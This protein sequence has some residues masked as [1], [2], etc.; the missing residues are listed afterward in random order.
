VR[1]DTACMGLAIATEIEGFPPSDT[2]TASASVNA[3]SASTAARISALT[4]TAGSGTPFSA[5]AAGTAPQNPYVDVLFSSTQSGRLLVGGNVNSSSSKGQDVLAGQLYR[6]RVWLGTSASPTD[7][8]SF[9]NEHATVAAR[10]AWT[11]PN[12]A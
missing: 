10:I 8:Y 11:N 4:A 6:V 3:A 5:L 9:Y 12:V 2:N 1:V 7:Y